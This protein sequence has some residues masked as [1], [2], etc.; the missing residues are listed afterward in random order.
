MRP[1]LALDGLV[2]L[3]SIHA[4]TLVLDGAL[5][6]RIEDALDGDGADDDVTR[7]AELAGARRVEP[8]AR[9]QRALASAEGGP[10]DV[11]AG[12]RLERLRVRARRAV[13]GAD[14]DEAD[15]EPLERDAR[16]AERM[17]QTGS[18]ALR[19][20]RLGLAARS[21]Q[22]RRG[23]RASGAD[24]SSGACRALIGLARAVGMDVSASGRAGSCGSRSRDPS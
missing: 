2:E 19:A 21:A 16:D 20:A 3:D 12:L 1:G 9:L 6:R 13:P 10:G 7:G 11:D 8:A 23:L 22:V 4:L 18:A 24:V 15:R 5:R 17:A 14:L